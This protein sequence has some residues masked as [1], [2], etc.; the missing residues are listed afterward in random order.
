MIPMREGTKEV[1]GEGLG[2]AE[3][4]QGLL[5]GTSSSGLTNL[6]RATHDCVIARDKGGRILCWNLAAEQLYGWSLPEARGHLLAGLLN[7]RFPRPLP[8]IESE[9][10]ATGQWEGE[11][12]HTT[13]SGR[14]VVVASRWSVQAG[15]VGRDYA[16]LQVE[17]DLTEQRQSQQELRQLRAE[18]EQNTD[19]RLNE[20]TTATEALVESEGRFRQVA[21]AIHDV[22][23]LTNPSR[24]S[25]VYVNP[26]YAALWGR[27]CESLYA[28]P[29]SWLE[30]VYVEDAP[31][32]RRFFAKQLAAGAHEHYYRIVRPDFSVRWVLDRGFPVR[33]SVGGS[34]RVVGIVR[35]VT[36]RK[37]LEEG[38]LA[39]SEREQHRLGQD[40]HDDLCQQLTGI[41][42]L[43]KALQQRLEGQP[44]AAKAGEIAQLIRAAI[45]HTR[46]L[47]RGLAP[48]ELEALGLTHSLQ[49]LAARSSGL[50]K[51]ECS[52]QCPTTVAVQDP[53]VRTHLY[54]IAQE[55]VA[56]SIQ[57]GKAT[58]VEMVLV[59][60]ADGGELTI[61]DNG[62][63]LS[64]QARLAPGMGLRVMRYRA[65]IIGASLSI[66]SH[67][68]TTTVRCA[69]PLSTW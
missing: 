47:A 44:L 37:E 45:A 8:E 13:R 27:S 33:E 40:L 41:E 59:A 68:G 29:Q 39:I 23:W 62:L 54:R 6:L 43:S 67:P 63:G 49:A 42:L 56:N 3:E 9:L 65:D 64:D 60:R 18:L 21:E 32:L 16:V 10:S 1:L 57:H 22:L 46:D 53:I 51:V 61:H 50:F 19:Q 4:C 66:E 26:A 14:T 20:L 15:T 5:F 25:F 69:F 17:R 35:D 7:T 58:R 31:R 36:E 38:L 28:D 12:A 11:L 55:A 30:A 52:F 48:L 34:P 2:V 24:T